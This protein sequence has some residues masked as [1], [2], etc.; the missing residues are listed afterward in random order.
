MDL[1]EIEEDYE[2]LFDNDTILSSEEEKIKWLISRC[3]EL[4]GA[5]EKHKKRMGILHPDTVGATFDKELYAVL[6]KTTST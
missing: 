4:E 5:I 2:Y 6:D 1:A 3:K